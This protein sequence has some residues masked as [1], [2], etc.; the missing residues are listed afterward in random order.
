MGWHE[1]LRSSRTTRCCEV[2]RDD[3]GLTGAKECCLVG[4]CGACTVR[5]NDRI[6]D[7]CLVLAAEADGGDVVSVEG[8]SQAGRL[9]RL[10]S[11]F[12]EKG[13]VQ[14]GF[15]IPGQIMAGDD[16][17]RRAP[18]PSHEEIEEGLAGNY[19]RCGCYYQIFEAVE[20]AAAGEPA[21]RAAQQ[22]ARRPTC[23]R[24]WSTSEDGTRRR[25][26]LSYVDR[27][28]PKR[29]AWRCSSAGRLLPTLT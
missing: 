4:E 3:L 21:A 20:A 1:R 9:T 25:L 13:A 6:V 26:D 12:L 8:L 10:Q 24:T 15:C 14:C 2:L 22:S 11:A 17:L 7:S 28:E 19:C 18:H 27:V 16:L 29:P 23:R 5:L